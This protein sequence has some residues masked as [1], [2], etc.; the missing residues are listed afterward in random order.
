MPT[1]TPGRPER[2]APGTGLRERK[3]LRTRRTL[4]DYA[5]ELFLRQGYDRTT[6]DEIAAA[7]EVS[8]RTFNRYFGSKEGVVLVQLDESHE[9][10]LADLATRPEH[11]SAL[12]AL[13]E[14]VVTVTRQAEAESDT[15][16]NERFRQVQQLVS[17]YPTLQASCLE[18]QTQQGREIAEVL[19]ARMGA[20]PVQDLRP[21]LVVAAV[22]SSVQ[23]ALETWTQREALAS[24]R[25]SALVEEALELLAEQLTA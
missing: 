13:R 2:S 8:P 9:R 12:K 24:G 6:V 22:Q 11:M 18:R 7:A 16:D 14:S 5:L 17:S 10:L 21:R 1:D 25:L 3:K 4:I 19:A 15:A 20:D 23:V